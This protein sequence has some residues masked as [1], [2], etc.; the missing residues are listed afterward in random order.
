M[1]M[2]YVSAFK[3]T[4]KYKA[5]ICDCIKKTPKQIMLEKVMDFETELRKVWIAFEDREKNTE[6][7]VLQLEDRVE[8]IDFGAGLIES[9]VESLEKSGTNYERI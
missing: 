7:R 3:G 8:S 5:V 6:E 2:L 9:R 4:S 1:R